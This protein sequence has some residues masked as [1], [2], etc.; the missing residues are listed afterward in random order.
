[1]LPASRLVVRVLSHPRLPLGLALVAV[2]L[3]R[4]SVEG[5]WQLDDVFHREVLLGRTALS[6]WAMF[7]AWHADR[8]FVQTSVDSGSLPWWAPDDFRVAFFRFLSVATHRFDHALWP[9][10]AALMHAQS[11][12][13]LGLLVAAATALYRHVLGGGWVAGLAALA[14]AVDD[15]HVLPAAWLANRNALLATLF[16]LVC[17]LAHDRWRRDGWRPGRWLAPLALALALAAGELAVATLGYLAAHALFL[18]PAPWR[19]RLIAHVPY[20]AVA[21]LWACIYRAFDFGVRGSGLYVD[22]GADPVRFGAGVVRRASFSLLGQWTAVPADAGSFLAPLY[23]AGTW[24][25]ALG[26]V[27]ALALLLA[28][29]LRRDATARFLATGMLLSTLPISGALPANRQLLFVGVGAMGL[30]AQL[31]QGAF[32]AAPWVPASRAWRAAARGFV[33]LSLPVHL[34]LAPLSASPQISMMQALAAPT[35]IAVASLPADPALAG[36]DLIVVNSPD[37]LFFV[38]AIPTVRELQGLP[39]PRR[40]RALATG[41]SPVAITRRDAQSLDVRLDHGLFRGV[42]ARFFR[43]AS[44]PFRSGHVIPLGGLTVTV[45]EA[46]EDGSPTRILYRFDRSLEDAALRWVSWQDGVY[47]PFVP[48]A[49]GET[50]E[51]APAIGPFER[52][53]GW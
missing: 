5:G 23:P 38:S 34:V 14:F 9:D 7:S 2:A 31:V 43:D 36:Q 45:L 1:M 28:P 17:I 3:T 22:P 47:V 16:G 48:P 29:L 50:V 49:L 35:E 21:A 39:R 12:A 13:W 6:P 27:I 40:V 20:A 10:S 4:R 19:R 51:L 32:A 44:R 33:V 37:Y 52:L 8:V 41:L 26:F 24:L 25:F 30:F 15:T 42:L 53:G 11:L 18:D 46:G